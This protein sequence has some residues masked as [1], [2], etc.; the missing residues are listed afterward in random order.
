MRVRERSER[1]ERVVSAKKK[2]GRA[3]EGIKMGRGEIK[4][5]V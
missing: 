2:Y 4:A 3:G 1:E 5:R